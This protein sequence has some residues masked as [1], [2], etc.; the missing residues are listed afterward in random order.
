MQSSSSRLSLHCP[1]FSISGYLFGIELHRKDSMNRTC[2][3]LQ[4]TLPLALAGSL[5]A[6]VQ[7]PPPTPTLTDT[8]PRLAAPEK[9]GRHDHDP[10]LD[11]PELPKKQV[12]LIG[13]TVT[14]LNPIEDNMTVR[15]FGGGK[16]LRVVFDARTKFIRNGVAAAQ[17]DLRMG[18]RVYLDTLLNGTQVFAKT[19]WIQAEAP[20]GNGRGQI[21]DYD[22]SAQLL[23]VR[24]ELSQQ[25]VRFRLTSSTTI[26]QGTQTKAI[27]DLAPGTLVSMT[28]GPQQDRYSTVREISVLAQPGT[29]YSFFGTITFLDL[30]AKVIA[31]DNAN[32]G[33]NY[34]IHFEDLPQGS[35][36]NLKRGMQVGISAVFDGTRYIARDVSA[37]AAKPA[38][39]DDNK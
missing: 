14:K 38:A 36:R 28:F 30:S 32:D 8:I 27:T 12:T 1:E 20:S 19:I 5:G 33:K 16:K 2:R 17:R 15:P 4:I 6:Q 24:E 3:F 13:G 34:E 11:L 35:V 21:V 22:P 39:E 31:I 37:A 18:D 29:A 26:K 25:P 10:L 9:P 23:T 7:T